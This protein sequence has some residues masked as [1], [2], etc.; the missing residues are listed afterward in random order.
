METL[1]DRD[2][3]LTLQQVAEME[4][5]RLIGNRLGEAETGELEHRT[6]VVEFLLHAG[7][8]EVEPELQTVDAQQHPQRVGAASASALRVDGRDALLQ[9]SPGDEPV[10]ALEERLPPRLDLLVLVLDA[11]ER[12]LLHGAPLSGSPHDRIR[13][14]AQV[15]CSDHP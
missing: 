9:L 6:G 7:V 8:A 15:S 5:H 2:Q 12:T 13:S 11:A 14:L 10:H 4:D 1:Y 3:L